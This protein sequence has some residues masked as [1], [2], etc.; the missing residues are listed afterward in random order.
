M[1]PLDANERF[2]IGMRIINSIKSF[3]TKQMPE[4]RREIFC[5]SFLE[6]ARARGRYEVLL[7]SL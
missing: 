4:G 6:L 3:L 1:E 7:F 5:N 2:G